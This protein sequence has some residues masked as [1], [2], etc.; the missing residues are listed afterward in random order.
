MPPSFTTG[1]TFRNNREIL[2][3]CKAYEL[4]ITSHL[5]RH[6]REGSH[7][8]DRP[9]HHRDP[10]LHAGGHMRRH[11]RRA[12]AR[13]ARRY[14]GTDHS[15][16]HLSSLSASGH[17]NPAESRRTSPFRRMGKADTHRQ[18]RLSGVLPFRKPQTHGRGG[19]VPQPHRRVE[20][21]VHA[22]ENRGHPAHNRI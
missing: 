4:H 14:K 10:H 12:H 11:E 8:T 9:R 22:R 21:S 6:K 17:R 16:Q 1:S 2:Y 5:P 7:H 18:R 19:L 13:T 3:L 15:G 20:A